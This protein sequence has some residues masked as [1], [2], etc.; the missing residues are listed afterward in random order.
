MENIDLCVYWV[1]GAM[2]SGLYRHY[3]EGMTEGKI[4]IY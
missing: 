4:K 2:L 3:W 1:C